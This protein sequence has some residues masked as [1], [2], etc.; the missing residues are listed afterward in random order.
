[1]EWLMGLETWRVVCYVGGASLI[2]VGLMG[3]GL[4][5]TWHHADP[6]YE[7]DRRRSRTP[8][9][10][11]VDPT[12]GT[13]IVTPELEEASAA[14]QARLITETDPDGGGLHSW[15]AHPAERP[16]D[17]TRLIQVPQPPPGEERRSLDPA[18]R[19]AILSPTGTWS[20]PNSGRRHHHRATGSKGEETRQLHPG[21]V[22]EARARV[23]RG[24]PADPDHLLD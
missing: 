10:W 4:R 17:R 21:Y 24:E 22:A 16:L 9:P 14:Y 2:L 20:M 13:L 8:E 15:P 5:W 23:E 18:W 6:P 12:T 19:K 3:Y 7:G 1:M 11:D